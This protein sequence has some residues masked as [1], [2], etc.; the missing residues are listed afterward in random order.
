MFLIPAKLACSRA[1]TRSSSR[2]SATR[3][4]GIIVSFAMRLS[5]MASAL[6]GLLALAYLH[7]QEPARSRRGDALRATPPAQPLVERLG[8]DAEQARAWLLLPRKRASA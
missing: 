6:L 8:V 1:A 4:R 3:R 7:F 5:E 2:A